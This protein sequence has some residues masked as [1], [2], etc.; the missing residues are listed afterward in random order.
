MTNSILT[1]LTYLLNHYIIITKP[2]NHSAAITASTFLG[3][4]YTGYGN[5]LLGFAP[6]PPQEHK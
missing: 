1:Q 5:W 4:L 3:T 6:I 2:F